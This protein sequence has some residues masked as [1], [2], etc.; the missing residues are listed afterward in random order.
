MTRIVSLLI[1]K[2]LL[3]VGTHIQMHLILKKKLIET[4][5][6]D[7]SLMWCMNNILLCIEVDNF[8]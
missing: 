5:A 4:K 3:L 2:V 6:D 8:R 7:T 1:L